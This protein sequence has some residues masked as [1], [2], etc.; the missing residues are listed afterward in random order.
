M[1]GNELSIVPAVI[2]RGE[3]VKQLH[4]AQGI[5]PAVFQFN[6]LTLPASWKAVVK[7]QEAIDKAFEGLAKEIQSVNGGKLV[8]LIGED[9]FSTMVHL[10]KEEVQNNPFPA[11]IQSLAHRQNLTDAGTV[12]VWTVEK[13]TGVPVKANL[14]SG[15]VLG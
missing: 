8:G 6:K 3:E 11:D 12:I 10:A 14:A 15:I 9:Q 4:A 1:I 5:N 7:F 13:S 2:K